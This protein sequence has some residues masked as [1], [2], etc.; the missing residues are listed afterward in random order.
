LLLD[1]LAL[2][3]SPSDSDINSLIRVSAKPGQD[4][5]SCVLH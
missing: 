1:L 3:L 5:A 4:Q 2:H